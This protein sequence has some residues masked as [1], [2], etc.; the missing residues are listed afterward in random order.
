[1]LRRACVIAAAKAAPGDEPGPPSM[2]GDRFRRALQA[3]RSA[4]GAAVPPPAAGPAPTDDG[5]HWTTISSMLTWVQQR[6]APTVRANYTWSLLHSAR[7]ARTL[8]VD[9]IAAVEFGVAGGN[10][11]VALDVAAGA[12]ESLLGVGVDVYG[13]DAG[14]GI[15]APR[16][17]RDA[18]YLIAAGDFP[19]DEAKLRSRL[20]R[21]DLLIGLVE[22]T[23]PELV[24]RLRAPVGFVS[25][26]LDYYTSTVAALALFEAAQDLLL[27][28]VMCY[29]DD[30]MGYPW[31]DFNGERLAIAEFNDAH[32]QRKI[33]PVY[34][35]RYFLPAGPARAMWPD[36]MYVAHVL[37]HPRYD[38]DEGT[39]LVRRLDLDSA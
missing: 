21:S 5:N 2:T 33:S 24:S 37:D 26:D 9:R 12:V 36:M 23:V 19:M 10:G 22:D 17:R 1:M 35:L 29:F 4:G 25:V 38:E 30:V 8:G 7:I 6:F 28:R 32:E 31:G 34:G 13:L 27:P 11:L 16:D 15:P 20:Q 39:A 18:P 3:W 14:G